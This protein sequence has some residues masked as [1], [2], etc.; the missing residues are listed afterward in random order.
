MEKEEKNIHLQ[1]IQDII[2]R[3]GQNSFHMK[4]WAIGIMIAIFSFA[5]DQSNIKCILFTIMPMII[6]WFLDSYYLQLER[7]F[8]LLYDDVRMC[9]KSKNYDMRFNDIKIKVKDSYKISYIKI[10]FSVT[11]AIFYL[12]CIATTTLIYLLR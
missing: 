1:M 11:E 12:T 10:L 8:R 5:G 9:K 3:M 4:G 7:K 6:M 2:A